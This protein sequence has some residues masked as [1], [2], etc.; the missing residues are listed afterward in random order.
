FT[1]ATIIYM[2]VNLLALSLMRA[3]ER[4]AALPGAT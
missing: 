4:R 3:V 2:V 1:A